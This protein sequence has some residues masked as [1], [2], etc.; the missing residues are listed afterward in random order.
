MSDV[1]IKFN[2]YGQWTLVKHRVLAPAQGGVQS[3]IPRPE[4]GNR[5]HQG[6]MLAVADDTNRPSPQEVR[7]GR[8]T[9]ED[10]RANPVSIPADRA[11]NIK[12][13]GSNG[14]VID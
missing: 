8:K 10:T 11:N 1:L 5:G 2:A 7:V 9:G 4:V 6:K 12:R 3:D 14:E 13:F